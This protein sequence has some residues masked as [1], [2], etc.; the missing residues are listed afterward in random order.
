MFDDLKKA[1]IEGFAGK[2]ILNAEP[3]VLVEKALA[4]GEGK[5]MNNGAL[6]IETGKY[7]GRSPKDKFIVDTP[8][9]HDDIAWGSVNVPISQEKYL[10][11]REKVCAYVAAREES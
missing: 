9:I 11:L 8:D 3:A 6:L 2:A 10:A 1:G 7:T 4:N 5:L